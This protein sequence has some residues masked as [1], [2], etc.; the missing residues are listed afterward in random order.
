MSPQSRAT[1]LAPAPA[2]APAP[3]APRRTP[4]SLTP[5][6]RTPRPHTPPARPALAV[7]RSRPGPAR[8]PFVILIAALVVAGLIVLLLLNTALTQG[9]FDRRTVTREVTTL[10]AQQ[11]ALRET[12]ARAKAPGTL[13][14][15]ARKLGLVPSKCPVFLKLPTASVLGTPCPAMAAAKPAPPPAGTA[16]NATS[17]TDLVR[18]SNGKPLDPKAPASAT[19]P[20]KSPVRTPVESPVKSAVKTPVNSAVKSPVKSGVKTPVETPV[21]TPVKSAVKTPV[22]PAVKTTARP[23]TATDTAGATRS[24]GTKS[25]TSAKAPR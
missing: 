25:P 5:P 17:A 14:D 20:V 12:I 7:V 13:A 6:S 2:P 9:A 1:A 4:S 24:P 11:Q 21:K 18:T 22:K 16:P 8:A 3:H 10:T 15:K 19:T 23:T